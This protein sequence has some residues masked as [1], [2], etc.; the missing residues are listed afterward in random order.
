MPY[1]NATELI[2]HTHGNTLNADKKDTP[3]AAW[4]MVGFTVVSIKSR[5]HTTLP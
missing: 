4:Q 1:I 2:C 5:S 3:S